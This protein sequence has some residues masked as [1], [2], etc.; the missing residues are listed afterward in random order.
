[1]EKK[2]TL[3]PPEPTS[4]NDPFRK[5]R[6]LTKCTR[7]AANWGPQQAAISAFTLAENGTDEPVRGAFGIYDLRSQ[8]VDSVA[9]QH[10]ADTLRS[11]P[12]SASRPERADQARRRRRHRLA[13]YSAAES[14]FHRGTQPCR[15]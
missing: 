4:E 2:R 13:P 11:G 6:L 3:Q 5:S 10:A 14:P 7:H 9:L 15:R 1:M 8:R 12:L